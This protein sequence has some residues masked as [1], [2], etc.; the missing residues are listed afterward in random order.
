MLLI[1][2][3]GTKNCPQ[4]SEIAKNGFMNEG[5]RFEPLEVIQQRRV[6]AAWRRLAWIR[7][8]MTSFW[9]L[10]VI[11]LTC[12]GVAS[13]VMLDFETALVSGVT[14]AVLTLLYVCA[15]FCQHAVYAPAPASFVL[16]P[17]S[18]ISYMSCAESANV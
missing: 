13:L 18:S 9:A 1:F 8:Y 7:T 14:I 17:P 2:L 6:D 3:Q 15:V 10:C 4:G 11:L 12:V 5:F 16:L